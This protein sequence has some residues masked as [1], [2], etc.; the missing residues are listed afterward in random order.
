MKAT[1]RATAKF[2]LWLTEAEITTLMSCSQLHYDA[3]CRE[4][5]FRGG[6]LY[7]WNYWMIH[8]GPH[9][10]N[11]VQCTAEFRQLDICCKILEM[12]YSDE[13]ELAIKLRRELSHLLSEANRHLGPLEWEIF[14]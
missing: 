14:K 10:N 12:P 13:R 6:F 2:S 8:G 11:L 1:L 3:V 9:E 7:G 5:S 4:S